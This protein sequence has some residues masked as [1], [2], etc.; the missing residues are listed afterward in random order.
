MK[1]FKEKKRVILT[2]FNFNENF[3]YSKQKTILIS[4]SS[5]TKTQNIF[6]KIYTS[7]KTYIQLYT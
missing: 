5:E 2:I 3:Y 7:Q 1:R 4:F 6:F